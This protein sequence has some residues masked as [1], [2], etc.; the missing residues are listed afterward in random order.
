VISYKKEDS[1]MRKM[2]KDTFLLGILVLIAVWAWGANSSQAQEPI[3]LRYFTGMTSAHYYCS[4]MV[5]SFIDEIERKAGGKVKFE[6]YP[7]KELYSYLGGIDA[8]VAGTVDMGLTSIGHWG[9]Y[10]KVFLCTDFF[11]LLEDNNHWFRARDAI[12]PVLSALYQKQN[13]Q[14]LHY[15]AYSE[16]VIGSNKPITAVG[17]MKG[18]KIRAPVPGALDSIKG[19][20]AIPTRI[21]AAEMYDA[22]SK[23]AIDAIVTGWGSHYARKLYEVEDYF[24]GPVWQTIWVVFMNLDKWNS[25]PPDI[26]EVIREV[27]ATTEALSLQLTK[28]A[29]ENYKENLKKAGRSLKILTAQEKKLWAQPLKPVYE[30]WIRQ[31]D[32][33]GYGT[34]ARQIMETFERTR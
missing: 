31:C 3:K 1:A 22:M 21:A 29:D 24:V 33:A 8:T 6:F 12:H 23:G 10:N 26:R 32:K 4:K 11:L 16:G 13:V 30:R 20:G 2:I 7:G 9:G 34:E 25:L 17:D 18:M 27:S 15:C 19:W 14:V 5:P 28:D